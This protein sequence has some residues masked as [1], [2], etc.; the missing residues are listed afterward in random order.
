MSLD[1]A[2]SEAEQEL[3]ERVRGFARGE[4]APFSSAWDR[5]GELPWGAIRKMGDA[6][7][8]GLIGARRLGGQERS[9]V[10]L[11][12]VVE[13]LARADV[14]CA[15][16]CWLQTTLTGLIPGWGDDT[17]RAVHRGEQLVCLATSEEEAGSD[18]SAMKTEAWPDGDDYVVSG[19]KIHVSLVPGAQQYGGHCANALERSPSSNN[20]A[21]RAGRCTWR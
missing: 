6:G 1:F 20:D 9:F 2:F 3:Q 14:S 12:I 21:A 13:E 4:L 8:L 11:G 5:A 18:V 10:S 17:I 19:R 7:F 16:I 15:M